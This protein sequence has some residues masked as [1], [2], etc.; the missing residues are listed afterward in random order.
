ML[1]CLRKDYRKLLPV[2]EPV[3]LALGEI[4]YESRQGEFSNTTACRVNFELNELKN[5]PR[6]W[7]K[8]LVKHRR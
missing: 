3:K 1:K 4:L 8:I 7:R 6:S 5:R 2:L